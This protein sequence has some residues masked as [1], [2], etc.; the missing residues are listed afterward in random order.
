MAIKFKFLLMR[1]NL[2]V[3]N[4][5]FGTFKSLIWYGQI[6]SQEKQEYKL[7]FA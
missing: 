5:P 1:D 4:R 3:P 2:P 6:L 7:T